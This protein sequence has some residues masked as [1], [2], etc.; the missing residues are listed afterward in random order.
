MYQR[1]SLTKIQTTAELPS[2]KRISY[3]TGRFVNP[4]PFSCFFSF[5][6]RNLIG[7]AIYFQQIFFTEGLLIM[8]KIGFWNYKGGVGKT[9]TA[10]NFAYVL[11]ESGYK[12]LA[13][14]C[15]GQ[16]NLLSFFTGN[17][18]SRGTVCTR[19]VNISAAFMLAEGVRYISTNDFDYVIVD[20]PPAMNDEV[21]SIISCCDV[22]FVP[23]ELGKYSIEGLKEVTDF[24]KQTGVKFGGAFITKFDKH[25]VYDVQFETMLKQQLG[26]DLLNTV[27][28]FSKTIRNSANF[29]LTAF[30]YMKWNTT[31]VTLGDLFEEMLE[32]SGE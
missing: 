5:S 32:R 18:N 8:K 15:D 4:P 23:L 22:I 30:E 24:I 25:S 3:P 6:E 13:A 2:T 14:D 10:Q 26:N 12:V 1:K 27:V 28:P 17:K 16:R 20:L 29:D 31:V 19:Y 11:A 9:T 7:F 21:K